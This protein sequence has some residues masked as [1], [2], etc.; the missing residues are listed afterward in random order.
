MDID[1]TRKKIQWKD[2]Q[3]WEIQQESHKP[4]RQRYLEREW[5]QKEGKGGGGSNQ[6]ESGR[7]LCNTH[8]PSPQSSLIGGKGLFEEEVRTISTLL[9]KSCVQRNEDSWL[10]P[11]EFIGLCVACVRKTERN[12]APTVW[13]R[14]WVFLCVYVCVDKATKKERQQWGEGGGIR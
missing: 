1:E 3:R 8:R 7:F 10:L 12:K 9:R 13:E 2:R 4:L 11:E 6:G 14:E 5:G